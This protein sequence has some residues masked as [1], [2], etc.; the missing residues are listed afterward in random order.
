MA[1]AKQGSFGIAWF[2][3][4][5]DVNTKYKHAQLWGTTGRAL[6]GYPHGRTRTPMKLDMEPQQTAPDKRSTAQRDAEVMV[7]QAVIPCT[8]SHGES[9]GAVPGVATDSV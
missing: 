9:M 3:P 2:G 1:I 5:V 4:T 8:S 6:G 7:E